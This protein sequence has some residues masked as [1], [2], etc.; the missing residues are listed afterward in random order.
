M[1]L[2]IN[3]VGSTK[4]DE[5]SGLQDNDIPLASV[6]INVATAFANAGV[7]LSSADQIAGGGGNDLTLS[8]VA[9]TFGGFGFRDENGGT[10]NGDT[11]DLFTLEGKEIFLYVDPNNDNVVIGREGNGSTADPNGDIVFAIYL[12]ETGNPISGGR[13]WTALFE[14]L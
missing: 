13:F 3:V 14:P 11:S 5:T 10:L 7:T 4:I 1:A 8:D 9:G 6:P 2:T 12:E